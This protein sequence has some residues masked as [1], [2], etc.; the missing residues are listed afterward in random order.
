MNL[1]SGVR[2]GKRL[3]QPRLNYLVSVLLNEQPQKRDL[4]VSSDIVSV[5]LCASITLS[6]VETERKL[7]EDDYSSSSKFRWLKLLVYKRIFM[8]SNY[9]SSLEELIATWPSELLPNAACLF[10][11]PLVTEAQRAAA[12]QSFISPSQEVSN[13]GSW[14][15]LGRGVRV[16]PLTPT[17]GGFSCVCCLFSPKRSEQVL[18]VLLLHI[19]LLSS[20]WAEV[21]PL[22]FLRLHAVLLVF[23]SRHASGHRDGDA[24]HPSGRLQRQRPVRGAVG[25]A[26]VWGRRRHERSR[27]R[28]TGQR[29]GAQRGAVQDR[30]GE[31]T[32]PGQN[33]EGHQ[34]QLWVFNQESGAFIQSAWCLLAA[35]VHQQYE[36]FSSSVLSLTLYSSATRPERDDY[37]TIHIHS[38]SSRTCFSSDEERNGKKGRNEILVEWEEGVQCVKLS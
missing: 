9:R 17:S 29:L 38:S 4:K 35:C 14:S 27:G 28:G 36:G 20:S 15:S 30:T 7:V 6:L 21:F 16:Y 31:T 26:G 5:L 25:G 2:T 34:N 24:H 3:Q 11:E 1:Q 22:L 23:V 13:D 12:E 19:V 8:F 32:G 10:H 18:F 37:K 33:M